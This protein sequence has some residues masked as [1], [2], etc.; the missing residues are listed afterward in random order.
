[1]FCVGKKLNKESFKLPAT[2]NIFP[3]CISLEVQRQSLKWA[4]SS[5][6]LLEEAR[7]EMAKRKMMQHEP[8]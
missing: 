7:V 1:M 5:P 3:Q 2:L 4:K 8:S 6:H